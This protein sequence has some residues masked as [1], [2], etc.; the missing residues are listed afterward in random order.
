MTEE[1]QEIFE[2]FEL[3]R[4]PLHMRDG[5]LLY[6]SHGTPPGS[7]ATAVLENDLL[8]AFSKADEINTAKMRDWA[9]WLYFMP[10]LCWGSK[11]AVKAWIARGGLSHDDNPQDEP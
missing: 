8:G 6:L 1:Q 9:G 5:M 2:T 4:L 3:H 7:F 11:E 10:R